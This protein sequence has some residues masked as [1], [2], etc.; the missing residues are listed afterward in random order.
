MRH[1]KIIASIGPASW[2]PK[3]LQ[4]LIDA[5]LNIARFNFSHADYDKTK[6][7]LDLIPTLDTPHDNIATM[8]DT[9]GPEIRTGDN[10]EI[11]EYAKNEHFLI[12]VNPEHGD[13]TKK[14]LFCDYPYLVEDVEVGQTIIIDSGELIVTVQG[15]QKDALL[16]LAHNNARILIKKAYKLTWHHIT[17]TRYDRKRQKRPLTRY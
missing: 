12:T 10:K 11:L 13:P 15:K 16:V 7:I 6:E 1:S 3:T 2:D 9:K 17:S 4:A 8:L 5:G 14:I